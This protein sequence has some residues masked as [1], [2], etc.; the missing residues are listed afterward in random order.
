MDAY[1]TILINHR[2][3]KKEAD[4][5]GSSGVSS[6]YLDSVKK[7]EALDKNADGTGGK[8]LVR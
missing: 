2:K 7:Y 8:W 4:D 1:N 3:D 6:A 5:K